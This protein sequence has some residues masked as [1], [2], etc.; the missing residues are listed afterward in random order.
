MTKL[1]FNFM[2]ISWT[3]GNVSAVIGASDKLVQMMEHEST[4]PYKGGDKIDGEITGRIEFKNVKFHYPNK[5]DIQ[6]LNGVSFSVDNQVNRVVALCGTSGC[7]KSS[8]ISLIERFYDPTEGEVLFNGKNLKDL[9]PHWYHN[10]VAIVQQ[11]PIL[12]SGTI[13]ENIMYGMDTSDLTDEQVSEKMDEAT[14]AASAYDFIHD[15][16][17]FPLGYDTVVGE[18]GV[19]LS[20]GQKQRIAIARALIRK[21]KLL[22]LDEATSALDTESEASVQKA[23]D[24]LI[25]TGE[26][27]VVV[28]A[29]RLSTIR[30][31]N[32]IIVMQRGEVK[33]RGTHE[34][35]LAMDG[36]YKQLVQRQLVEADLEEKNETEASSGSDKEE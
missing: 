1:L 22:L 25:A 14:R 31:A 36:F 26:Q 21:P 15:A 5:P 2:L 27:T 12:F 16:D 23:L 33:E 20:G 19:K 18:R 10:Q 7:G 24:K 8:I 28:V 34:S 4:I 35:L 6:I 13:G 29:H 32:E 3:F 11:E 30:D 17:L 9:D